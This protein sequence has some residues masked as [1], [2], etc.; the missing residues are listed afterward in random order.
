MKFKVEVHIEQLADL[1]RL[2][3]VI[4]KHRYGAIC[5]IVSLLASLFL[6]GCAWI[7]YSS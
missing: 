1:E 5:L 6:A 4:D 7:L 3:I 2:I